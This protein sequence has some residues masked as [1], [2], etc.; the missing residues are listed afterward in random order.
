VAF[1]NCHLVEGLELVRFKKGQ[2]KDDVLQKKLRKF[3]KPEGVIFVGVA[4]EK[5]RVP[6]TTRKVVPGGSTILGS[7]IPPPWSTFITSTAAT[8]TSGPS[9]LKFCPLPLP[10]QALP[11]P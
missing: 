2:R 11:W 6:R 10:R 8:G 4:Q 5:V 3:K 1:A 9:F 7:C